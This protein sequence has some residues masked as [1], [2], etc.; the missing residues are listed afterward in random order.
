VTFSILPNLTPTKEVDAM[1]A[2]AGMEVILHQ[3]MEA[4]GNSPES[5]GTLKSGMTVPE[6]ARILTAHLTQLPH[7]TGVSNHTGSKA[8]EDPV[9]MAAVMAELKSR[10]LFFLDSLTS[11]KSVG[12]KEASK[13]G[14]PALPRTVF[15]DNERGQQAALLMLAQAEKEA[16]SKGRA[17]AIGHPYPE[18][19]GALAV[20]SIRRDKTVRLIPLSGQLK[21]D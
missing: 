19:I 11:S 20:W 12:L 21:T 15:L 9:L 2:K 7:A 14:V 5:P 10:S 17:V 18:T 1:A 13:A 6:T 4:Y 3:P 8:T 16:K